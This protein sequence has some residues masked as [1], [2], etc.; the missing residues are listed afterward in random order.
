MVMEPVM[1]PVFTSPYTAPLL[2]QEETLPNV[3]ESMSTSEV[4]TMMS[5]VP[6]L[7]EEMAENSVP[8][9]SLNLL[10]IERIS[11]ANV[12]TVPLAALLS[13]VT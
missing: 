10:L 9:S 4:S 2:R 1:P 3:T 11:F 7:S 13:I 6:P 8:V 12:P 5:P